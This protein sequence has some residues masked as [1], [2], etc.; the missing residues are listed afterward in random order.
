MSD[1]ESPLK[2][3]KSAP[4][5]QRQPPLGAPGS[6]AASAS[7]SRAELR[8]QA[9][10]FLED[11]EIRDASTS[12]KV[13]FLESKGLTNGE[14]QELIG[15]SEN[16]RSSTVDSSSVSQAKWIAYQQAAQKPSELGG[17]S[18]SPPL[19]SRPEHAAPP[20]VTYPEFLLP[21]SPSPPPI[22]TARRLFTILY[23]A[24]AAA[25]SMYGT[26]KYIV[27]PMTAQLTEARRSLCET[28]ISNLGKLNERLESTVSEIPSSERKQTEALDDDDAE[29][30][31][32]D[33]TECFHV[34]AGTQTSPGLSRR[35]SVSDSELGK[36]AEK[37]AKVVAQE[38]RLKSIHSRLSEL[39]EGN[40]D[41]GQE[42]ADVVARIQDLKTYLD[43]LTYSSPYYSNNLYGGLVGGAGLGGVR[44]AE[45]DDAG[46]KMKSEIRGIKSHLHLIRHQ[47]RSH[48]SKVL[49][50]DYGKVAE[51]VPDGRE[52]Q[53]VDQEELLLLAEFQDD[54]EGGV[55]PEHYPPPSRHVER[56]YHPCEGQLVQRFR[57]KPECIA[58]FA[59][60][61][62]LVNN[63]KK[64][65]CIHKVNIVK[66]KDDLFRNTFEKVAENYPTLETN[67][68]IVDNAPKQF[69]AMVMPNLYGG[70]LQTRDV[71]T[72]E[73]GCRHVGLDIK[74]KDQA[75][76][77]AMLLSDSTSPRPCQQNLQGDL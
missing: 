1:P 61:F 64:V 5:W 66:P 60:S 42:E 38:G 2:E 3:V 22:L 8:E 76:P 39:V 63:R 31:D 29:T 47:Y 25:A 26:S 34:D 23:L 21:S 43:G 58:K 13:A 7:V 50:K 45:G 56:G 77:T 40:N 57:A 35:T 48:G 44:G 24:S 37:D 14:I 41:I 75:N 54:F 70:I 33:P 67:D 30:I 20:I 28:A 74:G 16:H 49:A 27:N 51:I 11:D 69:D 46:T 62:A 6:S 53:V 55:S 15:V 19:P 73:P 9:S 17:P 32:S 71:A 52:V 68:M 12:R 72:F 18:S 4:Q 59:F 65:T 10:K 36:T